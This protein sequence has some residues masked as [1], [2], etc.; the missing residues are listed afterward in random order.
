MTDTPAASWVNR[1]PEPLRSYALLIRL[2][3]PIGFWLLLFPAWWALALATPA[4]TLPSL[5]LMLAF[6][7]GAI[8]MRGA[9]CIVNDLTDRKL[10]AAVERTATRPLASGAIKPWQA[11]AFAALLLLTGLVIVLGMGHLTLIMAAASLPL[12]LAYPFMKRITWW[13]QAFLGITFNWGVWLGTAAVLGELTLPS[14]LL[15]IACF[16]WTLGYDTIYAFQDIRDDEKAGI[17]STARLFGDKAAGWV[18]LFYGLFWVGLVIAGAAAQ[19]GLGFYIGMA[20][21]IRAIIEELRY[22]Q[23]GDAHNSLVIFK[24][25]SVLGWIVLFAILAGKFF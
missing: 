20:L 24:S 15:Y 2:D 25:S 8:V 5:D 17:K 7:A 11:L 14:L 6:L 16:F 18:S 23:Q 4:G 1:L 3:R 9:G 13:P 12:I 22:W 19:L 10:D 21:C